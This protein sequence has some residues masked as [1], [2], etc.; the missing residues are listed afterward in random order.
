MYTQYK[1]NI[2]EKEIIKNA[3]EHNYHP[4]KVIL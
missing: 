3:R 4:F 1:N 2:I